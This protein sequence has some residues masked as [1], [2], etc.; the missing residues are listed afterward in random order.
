MANRSSDRTIDSSI[1]SAQSKPTTKTSSTSTAR[2]HRLSL[3]YVIPFLLLIIL[4]V[5]ALIIILVTHRQPISTTISQSQPGS[6]PLNQISLHEYSLTGVPNPSEVQPTPT[7]DPTAD[8]QTYTN[9]E[10]GFQM[11]YPREYQ[12]AEE[13]SLSENQMEITFKHQ[14]YNIAKEDYSTASYEGRKIQLTLVKTSQELK[15]HLAQQL[16]ISALKFGHFAYGELGKGDAATIDSIS[17][18]TFDHH[19]FIVYHR[20]GA[21]S[22]DWHYLIKS[23]TGVIADMYY[24]YGTFYYGT[25]ILNQILSTFRFLDQGSN[26]SNWDTYKSPTNKISFKYPPGFR[27]LDNGDHW[28]IVREGE[29]AGGK[30]YTLGESFNISLLR[31]RDRLKPEN[32][33]YKTITINRSFI[34]PNNYHVFQFIQ[35]ADEKDLHAGDIT[36]IVSHISQSETPSENESIV[37]IIT[38]LESYILEKPVPRDKLS[39][40]DYLEIISN[41]LTL[42]NQIISTLQFIN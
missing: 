14:N 12:A 37:E 2:L 38:G 16:G 27:V 8:W 31:Y 40:N 39:E 18:E 24:G 1:P 11:K 19:T 21:S 5:P 7:I 6:Y 30:Y 34:T 9:E 22:G 3:W 29:I 35:V 25:T 41:K 23:S 15:K 32:D 42:Y 13:N 17:E 20:M 4:L 10:Y 36:A 26:P 28:Q 33:Q